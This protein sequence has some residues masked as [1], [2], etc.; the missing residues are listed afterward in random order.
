MGHKFNQWSLIL[1]RA[2]AFIEVEFGAKNAGQ[3]NVADLAVMWPGVFGPRAMQ[4]RR[5]QANAGGG[6]GGLA[7]TRAGLNDSAVT[8]LYAGAMRWLL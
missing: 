3:Q 2:R 8:N 1:N 5:F 7:G 6:G 4:Q